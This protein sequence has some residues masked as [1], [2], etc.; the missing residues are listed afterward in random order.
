MFLC[1]L[2]TKPPLVINF[3]RRIAVNIELVTRF[4]GL[5][6]V[7]YTSKYN[8]LFLWLHLNLNKAPTCYMVKIYVVH[9]NEGK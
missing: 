9:I 3:D 1:Q 2:L 5:T 7:Q 8:S 4:S 6:P